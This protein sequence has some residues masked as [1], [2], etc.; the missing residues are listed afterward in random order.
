MQHAVKDAKLH[1]KPAQAVQRAGVTFASWQCLFGAA[2]QQ[3][4][5]EGGPPGRGVAHSDTWPA[6][7]GALISLLCMLCVLCMLC[8]AHGLESSPS[9]GVKHSSNAGTGAEPPCE[10]SVHAGHALTYI[11]LKNKA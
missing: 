6:G 11:Q 1:V 8:F 7:T 3:Q 5:P 10:P 9:W 2:L 4:G